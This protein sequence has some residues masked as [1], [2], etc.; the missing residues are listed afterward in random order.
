MLLSFFILFFI[1]L[2]FDA[3]YILIPISALFSFYSFIS[4][5]KYLLKPAGG[6][7]F[8][9]VPLIFIFLSPFFLSQNFS[10]SKEGL[11]KSVSIFFHLYIFNFAFNLI[12]D[13]F[14]PYGLYAL[15]EKKNMKKAASS[16]FLALAYFSRFKREIETLNSY[17]ALYSGSK[18]YFI[19]KPSLFFYA[20]ARNAF[21]AALDLSRLLYLRKINI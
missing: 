8:W 16:A 21:S 5:K 6:W 17:C 2:F 7:K 18:F 11:L 4:G 12:N 3:L 15:L 14:S 13:S 20:L 1:S 19:K 10:Y 9:I